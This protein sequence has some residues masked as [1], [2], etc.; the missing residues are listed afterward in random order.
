M[1]R[2]FRISGL[3][4]LCL[5]LMITSVSCGSKT[6]PSASGECG[7]GL[8]WTYNA[9]TQ[10]LSITGNGAMTDY[11]SS[12]EAPWAAA[13]ASVKTITISD[14]VLSVGDYAFYGFNILESVSISNTVTS[15]GKASFAFCSTVKNVML[16]SSVEVIKDGAFEGCS[17][18][19][20]AFIP[21][22]V[23]TL[24]V[25]TFAFC[26][27]VTDAAVLADIAIPANTFWNCRSME[28]LLL[29]N[30]ISSDMVD[31][32]AFGGCDI[33][34]ENASFTE[35]DTAEAKVT[36]K[37]IDT[38]G[39]EIA[40]AA[41]KENIGYGS[42]YSIV[43]PA[44][45]GY[46]ADK[47]TVTGYVY[48]SDESITVTYTKDQVQQTETPTEEE[49]KEEITPSTIIAVVILGVVLAG[50][51]VGAFLLIRSEKKN[52]SAGQTVRKNTRDSK[53]GKGRR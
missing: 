5:L 9:D 7:A 15:I 36:V 47:L 19:S 12:S 21:S 40:P 39:N 22:G 28:K 51:G 2:I 4:L 14:G 48:G 31:P 16:P 35:S 17:S 13:R 34:F 44:V 1:K 50:I 6:A 45:E 26:Y 42:S 33:G 52:S 32:S 43:S 8:S 30:T 20:A 18:L 27:S 41:V 11:T 3:I 10:V 24:G 23:K 38:E 49:P 53:N 37:Y 46:T 25:R 29:K